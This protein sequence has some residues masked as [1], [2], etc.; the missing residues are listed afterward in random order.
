MVD[1]LVILFGGFLGY[2]IGRM[3]QK[4]T[5]NDESLQ[6]QIRIGFIRLEKNA[7]DKMSMSPREELPEPSVLI[8]TRVISTAVHSF[9][10]TNQLSQL[11]DQQNPLTA[12]EIL[13]R[14]S[15][16]G[17]GGVSSERASFSVRDVHYSSFGK[18]CAVRT[19][20]GQSVGLT[21]YM[22]LYARVNEYGFLETPYFRLEKS[23]KG[24]K[25]TNEIVYLAAYDEDQVYITDQ[26]VS[27][28]KDGYITDKQV[29]LRKAGDPI[30]GDVTL[31]D[32]IEV[33]PKQLVGAI[34]GIIPFLQNDD[35]TRALMGTQQMSQAVPLLKNQSPI[36]G[37]GIEAEL[38][39]NTNALILAED[40]GEVTYAD[41]QKVVVSY[42]TKGKATYYSKKFEQTNSKTCF[43]QYTR[44]TT[45]QQI[46]KDSIRIIVFIITKQI[47][48]PS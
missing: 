14:L 44:V 48:S 7:R 27:M 2:I 26:S 28:D 12:L 5:T 29:P 6:N 30:L 4:P 23:D 37:T 10:A 15:L 33:T 34:A 17:P 42:K 45:G 21:N 18:I 41:G 13:R 1:V 24:V 46:K 35:V 25:V 11:Q 19:P 3:G 22:A 8:S 47:L 16:L 32:Y 36:V 9:F 40:D 31:A 43:N 39:R 20:E 38:A